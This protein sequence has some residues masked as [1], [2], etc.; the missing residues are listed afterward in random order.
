MYAATIAHKE[1]PLGTEV[2]LKN[3]LTGEM[4]RAVV[5]DRGSFIRPC[6]KTISCGTGSW[7]P[8]SSY[9]YCK[10]TPYHY[11]VPAH[12]YTVQLP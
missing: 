1:M 9:V 5:T 11:Y 2:E 12:Q 10:P 7:Q 4:A 6:P 8:T 3:T